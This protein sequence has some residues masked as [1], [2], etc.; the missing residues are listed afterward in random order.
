M[1]SIKFKNSKLFFLDQTKLPQKEVWKECKNV[2]E[3]FLAIKEL[4][5][6]GAPLIGVFAAYCIAVYAK[7]LKLGKER[8][9]GELKRAIMGL[10]LCRPTAV[11]LRWALSELEKVILQNSGKSIDAIRKALL[12]EAQK[13]YKQD[14]ELCEKMA[15][16]GVKLIKSG[17]N[18]LTHCN[19]GFLATAGEGT[20]LSLIYKAQKIYKNI[21]VYADETRPLL[22]GA[23]LTAWELTK[24]RINCTLICDN[25][26]AYLMQKGKIDKIFV[27]ADRIAANGDVANKIGTYSVA[28]AAKYHKVPFYVV[29]P[30]STFDL[31]LSNGGQI[32]IEERDSCEVKTVLGKIDIAPKN[33][34][35]FN[36]AF[37]VT[38]S[39]LITAIVSDRGIIYPPYDKNIKKLLSKNI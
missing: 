6:R 19:A 32:P 36:P 37:D 8:F 29:A 22:Q 13:I 24:R 10:K 26:A 33:V 20:A 15:D 4:K 27:G 1:F 25:M 5:V 2:R 18:I 34:K 3:G 30:F 35:V 28:V 31:S 14:I 7:N 16:F 17:D 38:P 39:R 23:R 12:D 11:N 21:K 9:L